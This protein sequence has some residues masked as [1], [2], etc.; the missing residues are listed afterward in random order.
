MSKA[1]QLF[2]K[3]CQDILANGVWDTDYPVRPKWEDGTPAHT[4]K[5][6]GIINRYNLREEFPILS[7]SSNLLSTSSYGFGR[8][9]QTTSRTLLAT[10]GMPG[11]I[12]T[13]LS[14]MPTG[15]S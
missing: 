1:D 6:F 15:T 11:Q 3:N 9:N 10:S 8:R 12:K 2:I 4:I 14:A 7:S 5:K 13:A